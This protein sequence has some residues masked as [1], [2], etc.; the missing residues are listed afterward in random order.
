MNYKQLAISQGAWRD[1]ED[2]IKIARKTL[3]K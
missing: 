3:M 1:I 2:E